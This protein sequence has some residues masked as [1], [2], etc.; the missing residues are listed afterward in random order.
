MH[1]HTHAHT[2]NCHYDDCLAY[3]KQAQQNAKCY[4]CPSWKPFQTMYQRWLKMMGFVLKDAVYYLF[5]FCNNELKRLLPKY[6]PQSH[7]QR[8]DSPKSR[9]EGNGL[10]VFTLFWSNLL[11][12]F[13]I[14]NNLT[15][16]QYYMQEYFWVVILKFKTSVLE[17][18]FKKMW[19]KLKFRTS[20][21]K[22]K[23][24]YSQT[25]TLYK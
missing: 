5:L 22:F 14:Q 4:T 21:K 18:T 9:L 10:E 8:T 1:K 12:A 17:F 13:K 15:I 20:F 7:H 11:K 19:W 6:V 23:V 3:R 25:T 24:F 16:T 2:P